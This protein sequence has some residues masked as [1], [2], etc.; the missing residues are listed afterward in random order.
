MVVVLEQEVHCVPVV[1]LAAQ[2]EVVD[3]VVEVV[4]EDF[5]FLVMG[6]LVFLGCRIVP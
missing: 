1:V 5:G 4:V 3:S 2:E 6:V